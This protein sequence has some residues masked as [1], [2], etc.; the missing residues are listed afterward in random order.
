MENAVKRA[1][2]EPQADCLDRH[3]QFQCICTC[4]FSLFAGAM[5]KT[6]IAVRDTKKQESGSIGPVGD[7]I[8]PSIVAQHNELINAKTMPVDAKPRITCRHQIPSA[9]Y[10]SFEY[11]Y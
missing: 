8:P 10:R 6:P 2:L 4:H 9:M 7:S 3:K 5:M 1:R 11:F